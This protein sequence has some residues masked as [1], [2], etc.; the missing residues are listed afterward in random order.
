MYANR[1]GKPVLIAGVGTGPGAT[2]AKQWRCMTIKRETGPLACPDEPAGGM[3][4]SGFGA[5]LPPAH[6]PEAS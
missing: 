3:R 5:G 6:G 1:H 2:T 4:R